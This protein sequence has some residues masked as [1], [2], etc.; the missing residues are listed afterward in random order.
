MAI[1]Y[2]LVVWKAACI[3]RVSRYWV[4]LRAPFRSYFSGLLKGFLLHLQ[5][6]GQLPI[7]AGFALLEGLA[8]DRPLLGLGL[9]IAWR[10]M[11]FGSRASSGLTVK[12]YGGTS[13]LRDF[14]GRGLGVMALLSWQET[15]TFITFGYSAAVSRAASSKHWSG[16]RRHP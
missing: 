6:P 11:D 1:T 5:G 4:A 2:I 14:F 8:G 10:C 12:N 7:R 9:G 16:E 15:T 13:K 3:R